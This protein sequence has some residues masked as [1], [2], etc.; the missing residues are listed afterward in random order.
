[1]PPVS[2]ASTS[3]MI[4]S[5]FSFRTRSAYDS[6]VSLFSTRGSNDSAE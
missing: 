2:I 3:L 4:V 6:P 5:H 1:M